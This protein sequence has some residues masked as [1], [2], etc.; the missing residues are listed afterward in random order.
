MSEK[1]KSK[2]PPKAIK[3]RL[4]KFQTLKSKQIKEQLEKS[5]QWLKML[6]ERA[7]DAYLLSD[8]KGNLI[9]GNKTAE[10]MTGYKKEELIGRDFINSG[11][12]P[13]Q[14]TPKAAALLAKNSKGKSTGPDEFTLNRKDGSQIIVEIRAHPVKLGGRTLVLGMAHDIT[15]RK[16]REKLLRIKNDAVTS[17]I[18]AIVMAD[19]EGKVNYVNDAFLEMWGYARNKEVLGRP[20][21]EFAESKSKLLEILEEIRQ[22]GSWNGEL[23]AVQKNGS[24]FEV[25]ISA[26]MVMDDNNKPIAIISSFA[27]ITLY[28]RAEIMLREREKAIRAILNATLD[29]IFLINTDGVVLEINEEGAERLDRTREE[30]LGAS[31]YDFFPP[32]VAKRRKKNIEEVVNSGQDSHFEDERQGRYFENSIYPIFDEKSQVSSLAIYARDITGRKKAEEEVNFLASFPQLDPNP[33]VEIDYSGNVHYLNAAAGS[34]FPDLELSGAQ[35]PFLADLETLRRAFE[36]QKLDNVVREIKIDELWFQQRIYQVPDTKHLRIY[37]R[38]ITKHKLAEEMGTET[39]EKYKTVV[40]NIGVGVALINPDF[41]ILSLNKKMK[42][43]FP[44]ID[45]SKT[46]ICYKVFNKPARKDRCSYCP[47]CLTLK[48]GEVHEAITETPAGN[49]KIINYRIISS[50]LKDTEGKVIAAIEM[51]EDITQRRAVEEAVKKERD[52]VQK[53]LDITRAIIVIIGRDGK[54]ELINKRGCEILGYEQKEIIGKNWFD[55]FLPESIRAEVK[56]VSDRMLSGEKG[57]NECFEN[58]VLTKDGREILIAWHGIVL[59]DERG[60]ITGHLS[61]GQDITERK[62]REETLKK[63]TEEWDKTF[64]SVSDFIFIQD[65]DHTII[66]ANKAFFEFMKLKPE[67][68]IGKKCYEVLHKSN[69]PWPECPL[70][71]T[72]KD[73]QAHTEE[74]DDPN[75][76]AFLLVTTSPM[77]DETDNLIGIVHIAKNISER[78]QVETESKKKI[79]DLEVFHKAAVDR[80]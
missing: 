22:K 12:L 20:V 66:K 37:G 29:S 73:R 18:S 69:I 80:E 70:E 56:A 67:D 45:V 10:E 77:F 76:G 7:P 51:V 39:E 21:T 19:F 4:K 8:L 74:V 64:N 79:H 55:N 44:D 31:V 46:P 33:I 47:T 42:E 60:N 48:D 13:S 14:E 38:D 17:S 3:P 43:W 54:V 65:I 11:L 5:D 1:R 32:E 52:R 53:Y 16:E 24:L 72:K 25:Q 63:Y 49:D 62:N 35:S 34:L 6:F 2:G 27:D 28:K 50:P 71:K 75:I 9:D 36:V 15:K 41:K 68:I 23:V 40:D 78:K 61:S 26:S 57:L 58:P 30:L 59:R